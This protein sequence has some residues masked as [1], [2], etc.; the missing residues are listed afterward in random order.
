MSDRAF[1]LHTS[2]AEMMDIPGS[3]LCP[4]PFRHDMTRCHDAL[5][6]QRHNRLA[7]GRCFSLKNATARN[8]TTMSAKGDEKK[9]NW[10]RGTVLSPISSYTPLK[11]QCCGI[12]RCIELLWQF[13]DCRSALLSVT[14][15]NNPLSLHSG[16]IRDKSRLKAICD[17]GLVAYANCAIIEQYELACIEEWIVDTFII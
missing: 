12:G 14:Q 17:P 15:D 10:G 3:N 13:S 4:P 6:E 5:P 8:Q 7:P 1:F 2:C 16:S 11:A 9:R